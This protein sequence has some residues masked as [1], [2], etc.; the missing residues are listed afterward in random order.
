MLI[1]FHA[2]LFSEEGYGHSLAET[3]RSLGFDYMCLGGGQPQYG[4][5]NNEEVLETAKTYP[6]L[7]I[8]FAV[9]NLGRDGANEVQELRQAGFRG[10]RVAVPPE[11]YDSDRFNP[12][13]EA[14]QALNMPV[15]FH[16]GFAPVT[17]MDGALDVRCERMR[18][19]YLDT[20]ARRFPGLTIVGTS[21]GYP[22]CEEALEALRRHSNLYFDIG[23][24]IF[25]KKGLS[26]FRGLFR[27]EASPTPAA[28]STETCLP[29]L[30][31]GS[32]VKHE[33]IAAAERD[34]QR[35]FRALALGEDM[36]DTIMG[37]KAAE[38]LRSNK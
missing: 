16:T 22:W 24:E 26:F 2:H 18:P 36:I 15:M 7:F 10:L 29:Q 30:L 17:P 5:A 8:P 6:E 12:V 38:L 37:A 25:Q 1:D 34:H 21:L 28:P 14:A 4:L 31:F 3:A 32:A 33:D 9:L 13:Y 27:A 23:G 19:V 20:L 35:F 11:P